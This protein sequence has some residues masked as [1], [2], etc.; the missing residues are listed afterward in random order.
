LLRFYKIFDY[1][2]IVLIIVLIALVFFK[3]VPVEWYITLI[4][5]SLILLV[6]RILFKAY[7]LIL[8]KRNQK[9]G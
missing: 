7:F 8:K 5:I 6:I 4:I 1:G 3:L 9:G 2:S